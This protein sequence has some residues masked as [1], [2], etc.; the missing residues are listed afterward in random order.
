MRFRADN[1][2]TLASVPERSIDVVFCV[3]AF[4]H[5]V[6]KSAVLRSVACDSCSTLAASDGFIACQGRNRI[7]VLDA[8]NLRQISAIPLAGYSKLVLQGQRL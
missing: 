5:M 6:D 3:G 2:E 4:E 8:T 1:A 7:V